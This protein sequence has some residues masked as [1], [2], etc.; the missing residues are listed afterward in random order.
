LA[1]ASPIPLEAPVTTATHPV[2]GRDEVCVD[3]LRA[4]QF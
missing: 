2:S 3:M 4:F 1:E